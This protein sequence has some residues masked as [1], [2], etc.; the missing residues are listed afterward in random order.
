MS[1]LI[2]TTVQGIQNIKYDASTTAMTIDNA[3]RVT[4]PNN[5]SFLTYGS[6]TM[7]ATSGGHGYFHS[8]GNSGQSFNNGNH[9]NN[10]TGTFTA[11]VAGKY[12]FGFSIARG[13]SYNGGNQLI[14]IAKNST[15]SGHYVGS[16]A[17]ASQANDQIQVHF[18]YD[19]AVNDFVNATYYIGAGTFTRMASSPRNYFY[20]F[21]IG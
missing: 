1:T 18:I 13:E 9:Y 7:T 20:G 14:Y 17:S 4:T 8:F 15:V 12:M 21:L 2:T 10:S 6:P 11:P 16:N 19:L 5:P 3:G